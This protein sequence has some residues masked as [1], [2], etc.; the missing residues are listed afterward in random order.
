MSVDILKYLGIPGTP[1]AV[2]KPAGYTKTTG[3]FGE[4]IDCDTLQCAHCGG[5]WEVVAGSGK[6]RGFCARC[7]GYVCGAP[8]CMAVCCPVEQRLENIEA[9]RPLLT[10]P[11]ARVNGVSTDPNE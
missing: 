6:L 1:R 4:I 7:D 5:H 10:T 8:L 11:A 3:P 9:G 2:R